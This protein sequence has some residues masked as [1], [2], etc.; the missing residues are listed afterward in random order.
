[1]EN[2]LRE[3]MERGFSDKGSGNQSGQGPVVTF[4]RES[5]CPS[6]II[7]QLLT[8]ALNKRK[9]VDKSGEWRFISK[10]VVEAAARQLELNPDEVTQ[11]LNSGGKG[12]V[13]DIMA[14][15]SQSYVSDHRMWKTISTV[16]RSIAAQGNVVIV[17]RVGAGILHNRPNTIHI[18]LQAPV[19]W[20]TREISRLRNI[21]EKEALKFIQDIDKKRSALIELLIGG[22]IHPHLFDLTFNCSTLSKEEIV[23]TIIGLMEI[24]KMI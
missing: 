5:G 8:D 20:R 19:E 22:K 11:L 18:R 17:G 23:H 13:E 4:S 21:T 1:M 6:K 12:M 16:V 3:Y 14:S 24:K 2:L 9:N 10:E 7:A 15:F